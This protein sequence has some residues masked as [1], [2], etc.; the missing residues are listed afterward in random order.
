[1]SQHSSLDSIGLKHGTDK[2]SFHHNYLEFYE[3]FFSPIRHQQ[4]NI[5]EIGVQGGAS[6]RTWE[7]YFP[8]AT[9]VGADIDGEAKRFERGRVAIEILDQSNIEELT[10]AAVKRGPFD[11]VIEDGSH[12]C[13][14]QITSLRTLFPFLKNGGIYIVEDLQTNYGAMLEKYRG[15]ATITCVEYLKSLID[16]RVGDDEVEIDK[17]EDAFLRSYGRSVQ[18]IT[19]YRRACLLKKNFIDRRIVN[20]GNPLLANSDEE[21]SIE[22]VIKAHLSDLGDVFGRDG[23]VNVGSKYSYQELSITSVDSVLEYRVRLSDYAWSDWSTEGVSLGT[24]GKALPLR[25]VAVRLRDD[26]RDRYSISLA[27]QFAD[28]NDLVK[29]SSGEDCISKTGAPLCGLQVDL[30]KST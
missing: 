24:R 26:E 9:I 20:P 14:H 4:L 6:L 5:L 18:F 27:A 2:A 25:G 16:L 19:F 21:R 8:A 13:E 28:G 1:M 7:E 17:I 11:I 22:V 29:A 30:K 23:F 3:Q 12:F 10:Q 15:I